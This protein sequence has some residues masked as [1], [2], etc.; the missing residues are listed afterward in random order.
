VWDTI[1]GYYAPGT[2]LKVGQTFTTIIANPTDRAPYG[3]YGIALQNW[4]ENRVNNHSEDV[5]AV[6][7]FEYYGT[8][9]RWYTSD[10][11][12]DYS[13]RPNIYDLDT[14][15]NGM[16]IDITV[17]GTN[18]YHLLLTPLGNPTNTFSED[19]TFAHPGPIVWVTYELYNTDSNFY[20]PG[21]N[22]A[23]CGGPDRTDFYIKSMAVSGLR[24][25]I[26]RDGSN[27][28]L[29][30]P[31]FISGFKLE[32]TPSLRPPVW[33]PVSPD[34][35]VVNDRNVVTNAIAGS[36]QYYRLRLSQ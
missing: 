20:P 7:V 35:V 14:T 16:Q 11:F 18:T 1:N 5:V 15:T 8:H 3:G 34:P 33:N 10:T 9:G 28:I 19:G 27:V 17:T 24:L 32:S 13:S 29:S 22:Y 21:G 4:P 31:S 25:D 2:G 36:Q 12:D 23:G 26:Q 6:G 30:W